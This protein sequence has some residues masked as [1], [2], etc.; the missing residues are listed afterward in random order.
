MSQNNKIAWQ[1]WNAVIEEYYSKNSELDILE[2]LLL[3]Q[4]MQQ[5][6]HGEMPIKLIHPQELF[7]R[8][9]GCFQLILS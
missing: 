1:S 2:E 8:L 6:T 5:D 9:M 3:A 7:T 4:E